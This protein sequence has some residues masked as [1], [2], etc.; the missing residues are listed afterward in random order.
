MNFHV[1][2]NNWSKTERYQSDNAK[3]DLDT[4]RM[5]K[6]QLM[7]ALTAKMEEPLGNNVRTISLGGWEQTLASLSNWFN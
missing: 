2:P 4:E 1:S 7:I 5:K 3:V 6:K